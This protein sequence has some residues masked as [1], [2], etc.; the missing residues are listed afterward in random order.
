MLV[1]T[2]NTTLKE[3]EGFLSQVDILSSLNPYELAKLSD[4]ISEEFFEEGEEIVRQGEEGKSVFF[5][6]DGECA[7]Y[8]TGEQGEI[9][10]KRYTTPGEY[11][12]EVA[13]VNLEP[14]RA[15]VRACGDCTVLQLQREDV[16][17][18]IG[19]LR[20]RLIANI[21]R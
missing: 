12:G 9:E 18:S 19:E 1:T 16:D 2:E 4:L 5:L 13:L 20:A 6:H 10:V 7:A 11:F 21:D 3:Y 15:T 17:L 8:M 14:R